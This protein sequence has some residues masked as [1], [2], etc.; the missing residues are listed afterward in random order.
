MGRII[1]PKPPMDDDDFNFDFEDTLQQQLEAQA[2][3]E[4]EQERAAATL[5]VCSCLPLCTYNIARTLLLCKEIA[6]M[7]A[8]RYNCFDMGY[9]SRLLSLISPCHLSAITNTPSFAGQCF[10]TLSNSRSR[11]RSC[12]RGCAEQVWPQLP[13]GEHPTSAFCAHVNSVTTVCLLM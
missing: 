13:P 12:C 7:Y 8:S 1:A 2:A 5:Q 10:A 3:E 11:G 4:A 6:P 9:T